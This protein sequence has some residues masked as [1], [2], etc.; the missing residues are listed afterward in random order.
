M[1]EHVSTLEFPVLMR[2]AVR[3]HRGLRRPDNWLQLVRFAVV[4]ATGY[5]VNL[6]AYAL[7]AKVLGV[8]YHVAAGLAFVVALADTFM[9]NRHWTFEARGGQPT[10]QITR[11]VVVALI[12]FGVSLGILDMLVELAGMPKFWAQ[13]IALICV[14]PINFLGNK[15]WSFRHRR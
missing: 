1:A 4:G 11:Y 9:L 5:A 8:E 14:T 3:L 15:L 2:P 10:F 7:L 13:A 12:A 6:G